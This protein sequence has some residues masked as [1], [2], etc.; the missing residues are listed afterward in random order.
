MTAAER[1]LDNDYITG[2]VIAVQRSTSAGECEY[3]S[4][5]GTICPSA[6]RESSSTREYYHPSLG[7]VGFYRYGSFSSTYGGASTET[8][9]WLTAHSFLGTEEP[10]SRE[11][12]PNDSPAQAQEIDTGTRVAADIQGTDPGFDLADNPTTVTSAEDIGIPELADARLADWFTFALESEQDVYV[13][14]EFPAERACDLDLLL[15]DEQG[16]FLGWSLLDNVAL[17]SQVEG[18]EVRLGAGRYYVGIWAFD[19]PSRISY[20]LHIE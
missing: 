16:V 15:T 12:E 3:F 19:A 4:G 11:I 14:L 5:V 10:Q 7:P 9:G 13:T 17:D 6:T 18:F 20:S 8:N 1:D 2:R